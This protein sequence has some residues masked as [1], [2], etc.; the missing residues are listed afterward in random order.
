MKGLLRRIFHTDHIIVATFTILIIELLVVVAINLDFL[1]PVVRALESFSMTDV[2]Y[3][4]LNKDNETEECNTITLVDM[5]ELTHRQDIAKV[6]QE[7]KAMKPSV[8]GVDIIFEGEIQDGDGDDLLA[9]ACLAND[10]VKTVWASKMTKYDEHNHKYQNCLHSFFITQETEIEGFI[11]L[12]DDPTKTIKRYAVTLPYKDTIAYSLPARIARIIKNTDFTNEKNHTIN[13]KPVTFPVVKYDEL[14]S[15]PELIQG[16]TVLLG[17]TQEEREMYYTPIGQKSG[18][19]ILA[20]TIL[21]MTET[22]PVRHAS[23]W[24]IILWALLAGYITNLI[25]Y[26]LTKNFKNRRSTFMVFI[27]QSEFYDKIISFFVMMLITGISFH[28]YAKYNYYVDTVLALSTIVL[29][30]EG[31]LL[32]AGLLSVLKKKTKWK[33]VRKSIYADELQ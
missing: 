11:N 2:Y 28:L 29:I 31:R 15:Y 8:L 32:Y 12:V 17:T 6:I 24:I 20:Y 3:K 18:M 25:D 13:Y 1:S 23:Q 7:I 4:I 22:T 16:H 27:T 9:Q 10:S 30:E 26:L 5:T 19:E 14:S 33:W 21:S